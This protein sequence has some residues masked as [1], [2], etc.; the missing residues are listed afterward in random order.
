MSRRLKWFEIVLNLVLKEAPHPAVPPS[1]AVFIMSN[2]LLSITCILHKLYP[3]FHTFY[4]PTWLG[5]SPTI[6]SLT[7]LLVRRSTAAVPAKRAPRMFS[8][9]ALSQGQG[10][11]SQK[12]DIPKV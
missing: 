1:T 12:D 8:I 5:H 9:R 6:S 11:S 3:L 4:T 2:V 10:T 7:M